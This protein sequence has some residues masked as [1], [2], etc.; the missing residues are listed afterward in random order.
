MTIRDVSI[1]PTSVANQIAAGEVVEQPS[2]VVKELLENSIDAG[3]KKISICVHD[4]GQSLID[5]ND[6][7]HGMT[8]KNARTALLR[9][10]TSKIQVESDLVKIS[11]LGFRGEALP[12]IASVSRF[13]LESK[14]EA[15][16]GVSI[17]VVGGEVKSCS[18]AVR[19]VGTTI[20]VQS[21]FFNVPAR[22]KFLKSPKTDLAAVKTLVFD[23]AA[24]YP[25]I[26]FI[27]SSEEKEL[28]SLAPDIDFFSRVKQFP[29]LGRDALEVSD[30]YEIDKD[31]AIEISGV[32]SDPIKAASSGNKLR[33]LVNG[34]AV[35]DKVIIG[36]VR[37]GYGNYLKPGKF[38]A[39]V[40]S[41][42]VPP[43]I[44]DVNI[45]PRKTEIRFQDSSLIFKLVNRTIAKAV[46]QSESGTN[47]EQNIP[48]AVN[49]APGMFSYKDKQ[50]TSSPVWESGSGSF[51]TSASLN[52]SRVFY[53]R[54]TEHRPIQDISPNNQN[55]SLSL[56]EYR[57]V[58]QVLG[59]FLLLEGPVDLVVLDMHAAHERI[60]YAKLWQGY[61]DGAIASQILLVP[62]MVALS[63]GASERLVSLREALSQLGFEI[64]SLGDDTVI[65]RAVPEALSKCNVSALIEELDSLNEEEEIRIL[66]RDQID[67]VIARIACH[68]SI[69]SGRILKR[70]EV[71]SLLEELERTEA[72]ARC[73]HGRPVL[74][75]FR[76]EELEQMFGRI[77]G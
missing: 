60:V 26:Q 5:I 1:L 4:G 74:K 55:E 36:A 58:G 33:L 25:Q 12:S 63:P 54:T 44:V 40:V 48:E 39:G 50:H 72:G 73:P 77:Q 14:A 76:R 37:K 16:P 61:N 18:Q 67:K 68:G 11:S 64:D 41:V 71:Y 28:I 9:F 43:E 51:E 10:G 62:E 56:S 20:R 49:H 47:W 52:E 19:D 46:G 30:S 42:N 24:A 69:R 6:D 21:L 65:V 17:D 66:I 3:A 57:F 27:L 53:D 22:K 45:H 13:L 29:W 2:S 70:E 38:P 15:H 31:S 34:R 23:Y 8:E 35:R 59:C 32:I 75:R 7:G